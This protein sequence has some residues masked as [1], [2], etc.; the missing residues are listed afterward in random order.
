MP[1]GTAYCAACGLETGAISGILPVPYPSA[2]ADE[3]GRVS[4]CPV[5]RNEEFSESARYCRICGLPLRN[6]CA[7]DSRCGR[8][9]APGAAYCAF[10]GSETIYARRGLL[11]DWKE[12]REDY[13]RRLIRKEEDAP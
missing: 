3:T 5:C 10:C 2:P 9:A 6:A 8:T 1:P 13:I 11:P 12:V 4:L 7:G